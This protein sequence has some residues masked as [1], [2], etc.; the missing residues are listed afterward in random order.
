MVQNTERTDW[1]EFVP[2][3][4]SWNQEDCDAHLRRLDPP[5]SRVLHAILSEATEKGPAAVNIEVARR[6]V[7]VGS[8]T[9]FPNR[10]DADFAV[11]LCIASRDRCLLPSARPYPPCRWHLAAYLTGG[12]EW[13]QT[14]AGLIGFSPAAITAFQASRP[15]CA[16]IAETM[17]RWSATSWQRLRRRATSPGY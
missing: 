12:V 3:C 7:S 1:S 14:Q 13:S 15:A 10:R 16:P 17:R 9:Y 6:A 5:G 8:C 4:Y 2:T 11:Q